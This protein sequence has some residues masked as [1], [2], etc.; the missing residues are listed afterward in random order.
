MN[1]FQNFNGSGNFNVPR[2]QDSRVYHARPFMVPWFQ[3][4]PR[5][6]DK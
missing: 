3:D 5:I 1:G 2:F 6:N 4:V